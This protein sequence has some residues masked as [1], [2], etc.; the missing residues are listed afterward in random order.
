MRS[1]WGRGRWDGSESGDGWGAGSRANARLK[2]TPANVLATQFMVIQDQAAKKVGAQKDV[3]TMAYVT[4]M[5]R[6][7]ATLVSWA[8]IVL[9]LD[10]QKD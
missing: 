8:K 3:P 1:G 9:K 2:V 5:T 10:A 7:N 6:V 4:R